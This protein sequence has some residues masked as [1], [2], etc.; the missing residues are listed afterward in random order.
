MADLQAR[1]EARNRKIL[2]NREKRMNILYGRKETDT[3]N[4]ST[5]TDSLAKNL[6]VSEQAQ[7][8]N[9]NDNVPVAEQIKKEDASI[10]NELSNKIREPDRGA[11]ILGNTINIGTEGNTTLPSMTTSE[12]LHSSQSDTDGVRHRATR[13]T[14][15]IQQ[16][17]LLTDNKKISQ[18]PAS[19]ENSKPESTSQ[20]SPQQ[21]FNLL[22]LVGCVFIAVLS[23][24]VL[25]LGIGLLYFQTIILPFA[26]L[27][28][29]LYYYRMTFVKDIPYKGTA[30]SSALMLCGL[31]QE[32]I[33]TY[34]KIMGNIAGIYEDFSIYLFAFFF[35]NM[36]ITQEAS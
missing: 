14:V 1:R 31:K 21:Q 18:E 4:D 16:S 2:Q 12:R 32:M 28:G 11:H 35:S 34:N 23:R 6:I 8:I 26:V 20:R 9:S 30:L 36:L 29:A 22:R 24:V 10:P 3:G 27:Q 19:V 33:L 17:S 5:E 7:E 25:Q 15:K 13:N